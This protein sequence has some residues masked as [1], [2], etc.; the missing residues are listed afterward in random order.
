MA[1]KKLT[2]QLNIIYAS[3]RPR[4][5]Q[6]ATTQSPQSG[7]VNLDY[8]TSNTLVQYADI[9]DFVIRKL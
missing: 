4:I 2:D 3:P 9:E 7:L 6:S 8:G 1:K 5:V